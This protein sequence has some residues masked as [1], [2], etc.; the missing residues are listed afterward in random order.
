VAIV[1]LILSIARYHRIDN[2]PL[3]LDAHE[4]PTGNFHKLSFAAKTAIVLIQRTKQHT[5]R[6]WKLPSI[7]ISLYFRP[8]P[9]VLI[10]H[11]S[12]IFQHLTF[13]SRGKTET[14][15]ICGGESL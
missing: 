5:R 4:G 15:L 6:Q 2:R 3:L 1:P 9:G 14:I 11:N 12:S 8:N 13:F 7:S 10:I